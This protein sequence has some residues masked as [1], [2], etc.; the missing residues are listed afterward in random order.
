MCHLHLHSTKIDTA[1]PTETSEGFHQTKRLHTPEVCFSQ[2]APTDP[3]APHDWVQIHIITKFPQV[4]TEYLLTY[5]MEQ[6]P[7]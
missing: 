2:S 1:G 5:S 3:Y 6:G 7:S 4:Q